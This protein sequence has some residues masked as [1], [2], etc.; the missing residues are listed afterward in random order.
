MKLSSKHYVLS[1]RPASANTY[2]GVEFSHN[3]F[4]GKREQILK[5]LIPEC[6]VSWKKF[7]IHINEI[8]DCSNIKLG[9]KS[10]LEFELIRCSCICNQNWSVVYILWSSSELLASVWK[11]SSASL[12][13]DEL[14]RSLL[15]HESVRTNVSYHHSP[16]FPLP[17]S[18]SPAS[19]AHS[20][21][22]MR[23]SALESWVSPGLGFPPAYSLASLLALCLPG[24]QS[25]F[26][27]ILVCCLEKRK[28]LIMAESFRLVH[29]V[30]WSQT[31]NSKGNYMK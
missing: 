15:K 31:L 20:G 12:N 8:Q 26:Y 13:S 29:K 27:P 1:H 21:V 6:R 11:T 25:F 19:R 3:V 30:T 2:K 7:Y 24:C 16:G 23:L 28:D 22:H 5:G 4:E 14:C 9:R 17:G 18:P 10:C